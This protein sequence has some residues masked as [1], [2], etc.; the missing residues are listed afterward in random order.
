MP[1]IVIETSCPGCERVVVGRHETGAGQQD[2]ARRERVVAHDPLGELAAA[3][4]FIF[5]VDVSPA[6]SSRPSRR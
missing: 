6:K 1:S 2:G 4:R 3:R 5:A